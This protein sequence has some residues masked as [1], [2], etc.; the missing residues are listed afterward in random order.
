VQP[1]LFWPI[2]GDVIEPSRV[3]TY[4]G[5]IMLIIAG[6]SCPPPY[7]LRRIIIIIIIIIIIMRR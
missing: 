4:R 1:Y 7:G 5:E 6:C 3:K 2:V